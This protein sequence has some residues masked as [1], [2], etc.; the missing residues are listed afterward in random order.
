MTRLNIRRGLL[1]DRDGVIN[2]DHGYVGSIDAFAFIPGI[3]A[4]L[5]TAID[6]GWYLAILTNQS[7]VARGLYTEKDYE[8]VMAWM[9]KEMAREGITCDLVLACFEHGDG[10]I[11]AYKRESFWRKPNPGMV[12]EAIQRMRLDP[13]R[14]AFLGDKKTD[15]AAALSAGIGKCLWLTQKVENTLEGVHSVKNYEEALR[16]LV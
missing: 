3:F 8:Q 4:F 10:E 5:R 12:L 6:A 7:G 15:M 16:V 13:V 9:L 2:I 1:L 11:A 14:S